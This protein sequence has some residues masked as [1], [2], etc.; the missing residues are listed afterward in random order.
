VPVATL[1]LVATDRARFTGWPP[2]AFEFY[3]RLEADNSRAFWLANRSVYEAVVRGPM[4]ALCREL[5]EDAGTFHLFRPNRDVRFSR[6]KS[7][8]KTHL[9]AVTEGEGGESYYVQISAEG[10]FVGC[11]CYRM[12][13]DQLERFRA[14]VADDTAGPVLAD[15]VTGLERRGYAVGGEALKRAPRGFPADHPRIRFLRH[16][17][18]T[19]AKA[20]PVA[21]AL[22]T[23]R[24]LSTV[25]GVWEGAALVNGWLARHVGPSDEPPD[26]AWP[27]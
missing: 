26:D 9:G 6:D 5:G 27:R 19:V 12:A 17:G 16:K 4:E 8:Y 20:F 1:A 24:V 18:L 22:G 23:R 15:A 21:P 2:A 25:R 11:G 7:P 13:R 14:A 10:L 3:E